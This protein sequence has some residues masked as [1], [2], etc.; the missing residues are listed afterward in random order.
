MFV[1]LTCAGAG[2]LTLYKTQEETPGPSAAGRPK[3][4]AKTPL[5][6][7]SLLTG[8]GRCRLCCGGWCLRQKSDADHCRL[9]AGWTPTA[10]NPALPAGEWRAV[11]VSYL[12]GR[13]WISPPRTPSARRGGAAVDNCVGLGLNTVLAQVRPFRGCAVPQQFVPVEP[14]VHRGCREKTPALTRWMSF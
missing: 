2:R 6:P 5:W 10:P 4:K 11:W 1:L 8:R 14:S 13:C 3:T 12:T 7:Q 9:R